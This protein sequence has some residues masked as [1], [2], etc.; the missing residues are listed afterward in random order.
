M[1]ESDF[2]AENPLEELLVTAQGGLVHR[3]EFLIGLIDATVF[4]PSDSEVKLDGSGFTPML[5]DK[6]SELFMCVFTASDRING[7]A[8]YCLAMKG[9]QLLT[10]LPAYG[11]VV[12]PGYRFSLEVS[13]KEV[14]DFVRGF[15]VTYDDQCEKGKWWK[16]I[17][18]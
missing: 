15:A 6:F 12:N 2:I 14:K 1:P 7:F 4:V 13:A 5:F 8:E 17:W 9:R 10:T 11:I 3:S 18:R 16:R